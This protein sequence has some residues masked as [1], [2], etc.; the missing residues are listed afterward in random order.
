M[1]LVPTE[2]ELAISEAISGL[3]E[4]LWA[5]SETVT[6]LFKD[7]K[8]L[9]TLLY[10][11]LW[12]NHRGF[13]QLWRCPLPQEA[14]IILRSGLEAAIC[15]AANRKLGAVFGAMMRQD[16]AFTVLGQIKI[17]RENDDGKRV[18]ES[19]AIL[20]SLTADLPE[21]SKA[22]KLDFK[23]LAQAG[24]VPR[25][26]EWHRQLSGVSSHVT[27]VS[28]IFG[29][30]DETDEVNELQARWRELNNKMRPMM[31]CSATLTGS[32]HHAEV[33]GASGHVEAALALTDRMNEISKLW[34][35][36]GK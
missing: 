21:S 10:K 13:V 36:V 8:V 27:G 25:L 22:A 35:G 15:I 14:D 5:E 12:S 34:P 17:H 30:T 28:V 19:E 3:G 4:S 23:A 2:D 24:E 9:S 32:L 7:P 31:M 6:G 18:A 16:A 20:R 1:S 11:R 29:V 26:Y 33:I